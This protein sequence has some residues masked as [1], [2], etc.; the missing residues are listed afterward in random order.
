[1]RL[2]LDSI[3]S[4]L[5]IQMPIESSTHPTHLDMDT[6]INI[7]LSPHNNRMTGMLTRAYAF[8][9]ARTCICVEEERELQEELDNNSNIKPLSSTLRQEIADLEVLLGA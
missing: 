9:S 2:L 8:H 5:T 1:M 4:A 6:L 3:S 7:L